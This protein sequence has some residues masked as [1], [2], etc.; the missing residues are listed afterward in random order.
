MGKIIRVIK[1]TAYIFNIFY[2]I[3]IEIMVFARCG[4]FI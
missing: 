1:S 2:E 3:M 4:I